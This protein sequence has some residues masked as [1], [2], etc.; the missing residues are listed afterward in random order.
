MTVW[1]THAGADC[2]CRTA[3]PWKGLMLQLSVKNCSPWEGTVLEK[4]MKDCLQWEG[5]HAGSGEE[6]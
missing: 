3:S 5:P 6:R 1:G 2:Y 4:F